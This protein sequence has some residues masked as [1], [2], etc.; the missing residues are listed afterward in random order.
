MKLPWYEKWLG[1]HIHKWVET[2]R[3]YYEPPEV[4][5]ATSRRM[6]CL[7]MYKAEKTR[8]CYCGKHQVQETHCLGLNPSQY[9]RRWATKKT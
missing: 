4:S 2:P 8:T 9:V 6:K 5:A 7:A 1:I 3:K